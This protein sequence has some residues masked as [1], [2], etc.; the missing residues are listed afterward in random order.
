MA[1][2][3]VSV[4]RGQCR[5]GHEPLCTAQRRR[6][7]GIGKSIN[8]GFGLVLDGSERVDNYHS[9]RNDVGRYGRR[10]KAQLGAPTSTPL[11]H[12]FKYNEKWAGKASYHHPLFC[13]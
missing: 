3:A 1:D 11:K 13:G 4:L 6:V 12:P 8:G 10:C 9:L 7:S 5:K 2:M